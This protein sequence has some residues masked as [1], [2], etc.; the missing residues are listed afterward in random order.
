MARS[1]IYNDVVSGETF[2]LD[3]L[4]VFG[5]LALRANSIGHLEQINSY[6]P[7]R[8]SWTKGSSGVRPIIHGPD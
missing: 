6:A 5:G 2:L 4:F 7:V 3:Q 1:I 8:E